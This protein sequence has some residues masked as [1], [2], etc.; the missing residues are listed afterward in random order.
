MKQQLFLPIA[1]HLSPPLSPPPSLPPPIQG[2]HAIQAY[3]IAH[4]LWN[5]GQKILAL[6]MQSRI[7]EVSGMACT[8]P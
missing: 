6:A 1:P 2:Y 7:S 5:R 3:R 8:K 4:A